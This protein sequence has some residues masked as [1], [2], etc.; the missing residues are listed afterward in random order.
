VTG[1]T[2]ADARGKSLPEV[3]HLVNEDTRQPV[4]NPVAK[5]LRTGGAAGL[6]N[7]TV[8]LRKDGCEC[9]IDDSAAPIRGGQSRLLGIILVFRNISKRRQ[10]E[11]ALRE[12]EQRW[13]TLTEALPVLVWDRDWLGDL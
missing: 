8:L 11:G 13:H 3:F 12:S 1:W 10:A 2:T 4:E 9:P 6:A 5:V 7:H